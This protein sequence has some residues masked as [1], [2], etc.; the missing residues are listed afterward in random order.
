M[1]IMAEVRAE[2]WRIPVEVVAK[3]HAAARGPGSAARRAE[4]VRRIAVEMLVVEE[5]DA[6][7]ELQ[8]LSKEIRTLATG[9]DHGAPAGDGARKVL[10]VPSH[11]VEQVQALVGPS[12]DVV[13]H[14]DIPTPHAR[15]GA[16]LGKTLTIRDFDRWQA[17]RAKR[18]RKRARRTQQ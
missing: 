15:A 18:E 2:Q 8:A 13:A 12:I 16:A 5:C 10:V 6:P 9:V 7:K 4:A 14:E 17:A 11:R 3:I 1:D